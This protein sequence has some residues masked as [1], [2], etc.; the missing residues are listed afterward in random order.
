MTE[1]GSTTA[2]H[3]QGMRDQAL[4]DSFMDTSDY[5]W[6]NLFVAALTEIDSEKFSARLSA[7]D[8]AVFH[9]LLALENK[10][11]TEGERVALED[12]MRDIRLLR[13]NCYHFRA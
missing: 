9:R 12:T 7:S 3:L 6:R 10:E 8:D 4:E 11:G 1:P 5:Q 2:V 13:E